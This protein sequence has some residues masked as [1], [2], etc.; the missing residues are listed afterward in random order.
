MPTILII[1]D[2]DVTIATLEIIL[3][4]E[5]FRTIA[6]RNGPD[7]R[8]LAWRNLPDLVLL[9]MGMPGEN[10]VEVCRQLQAD[11][12]TAD[13]PVLFV[14]ADH[15]VA[16]KVAGLEAG[17]VDYV[18]KPF[19]RTEV[20]AR[21]RTQL[22][23]R[24]AHR[25]MLELQAARLAEV[26]EAQRSILVRPE[27]LPEACFAV[28]F[29][30]LAAAG[31]DFYDVLQVGEGVFDYVVADV[32][33]HDTGLAL[34]TAALKA[35]IRQN[36]SLVCEP[37]QVVQM[38]NRVMRSI[39]VEGQ[40]VTLL[41]ARLNRVR[42]TATLLCAG[43]PPAIVVRA[44]GAATPVPLVGDVVGAFEAACFETEEL[45]MAPGD[46]LFLYSDGMVETGGATLVS[47][48]RG[49]RTLA[50]LC[51]AAR[52]AALEDAVGSVASAVFA[53]V[54]PADDLVLLCAQ[55]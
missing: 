35:L 40:Y 38:V 28:H 29:Q 1:D 31:G 20:L 21:V 54:K 49:I 34:A 32:S 10:G 46:R 53:D 44:G 33:G 23:L 24:H 27:D 6:A 19:H 30:P 2:D 3:Q 41:Y 11:P 17:G 14:S 47:R 43:H 25:A 37:A 45:S 5:G 50:A 39:L 36:A 42:G 51:A 15:E 4:R 12:R 18:T 26:G 48:D 13:V 52:A 22:R 9:D 8:A 7:G 16:S 55:M